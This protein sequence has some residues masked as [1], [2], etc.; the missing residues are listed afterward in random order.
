[1]LNKF[2]FYI[3]NIIIIQIGAKEEKIC[4]NSHENEAP[5]SF[6]TF[7]FFNVFVQFNEKTILV[8]A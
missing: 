3:A 2:Q 6:M 1:M 8:I 5:V 4:G 7:F